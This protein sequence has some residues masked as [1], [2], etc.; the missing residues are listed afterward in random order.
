MEKEIK[1]RF[2]LAHSPE[3]VWEYLTRSELLTQWLMPNDFKLVIGHQFQFLTKPKINLGFDGII[4]CQLLEFIPV[5]TLVYSWQGGMSKEQPKVDS[6]V[7]WTFQATEGGTNLLLEHRG[8]KGVRNFLPYLIM[9]K[10]WPQIVDRLIRKMDAERPG[11]TE[12][13]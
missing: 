11:G 9:N 1:R 8:F 6:Q 7:T 5:K 4:Y 3:L 12:R 10:S 2:F 13:F